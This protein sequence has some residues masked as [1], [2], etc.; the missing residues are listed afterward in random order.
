MDRGCRRARAG[1]DAGGRAC[2]ACSL[3]SSPRCSCFD[4]GP[5]IHLNS[6]AASCAT[7]KCAHPQE[8]RHFAARTRGGAGPHRS[9]RCW[10]LAQ[11]RASPCCRWAPSVC[12]KVEQGA[13]AA[14]PMRALCP[15]VPDGPLRVAPGHVPPAACRVPPWRAGPGG[16]CETTCAGGKQ[17]VRA[18]CPAPQQARAHPAPYADHVHAAR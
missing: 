5:G 4:F 2:A 3:C 10:C 14:V 8:P 13:V 17:T 15:R 16:M 6:M 12:A 9:A 11:T 7:R 18:F 1:G